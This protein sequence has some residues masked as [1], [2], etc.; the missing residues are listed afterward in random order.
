MR[1]L[2][3]IRLTKAMELMGIEANQAQKERLIDL[4]TNNMEHCR[5]CKT[6]NVLEGEEEYQPCPVCGDSNYTY[7]NI[8][9]SAEAYV[10]LSHRLR[11][12][13][14]C[15]CVYKEKKDER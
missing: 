13:E 6:C 15:G 2:L 11:I 9:G 7:L 12:C 1:E 8:R 14:R 10:G 3:M 5:N 4:V